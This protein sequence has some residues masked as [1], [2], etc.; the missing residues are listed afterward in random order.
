LSSFETSVVSIAEPAWRDFAL[1]HPSALPYHHPAWTD[2]IVDTYGFDPFAFV[3]RSSGSEVVGGVPFV[4]LGGGLRRKRWVALPFTDACPPLTTPELSK[5][6][7]GALVADAGERAGVNAIEVRGALD[8]PGAQI[9]RGV[10]HQLA[11][12]D[13][14]E[15]FSGFES[16]VR[17]NIRKADRSGLTLRVAEREEDLTD[18]YFALHADTRRRLGVPTQPRRFF[19]AVWRRMLAAGLGFAFLVY[20]EQEPIAGAVFLEWNGVVV[21][22]FGASDARHWALRPNNLIFWEAI[23][24][25]HGQGA[26][27]LDFGRSDLEDEGLRAFKRSW[28]AVEEPLFYTMLGRPAESSSGSAERLL[29]PLLRRSPVWVGRGLG[30]LFYRFGA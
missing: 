28:G 5:E 21:Y 8:L 3:V 27:V 17:R 9:E 14:D 23:K 24:R 25:A 18:V 16:Q 10:V 20:H 22:K 4:T 6:E 29:K 26:R 15:L 11:L 13:P 30:E 2:T 12:S 1:S 7:L 19:A